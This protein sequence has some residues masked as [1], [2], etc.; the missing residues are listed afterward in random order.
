MAIRQQCQQLERLTEAYLAGIVLLDEYRR[1]RSE[2]ERRS[3]ALE[4]QQRQLTAPV[5][6]REERADLSRSRENFCQRIRPG[7]EQ[8]T[9]EQKRK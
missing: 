7:R 8:A 6:R 9:F 4:E 5:D 1:R 2:R 3:Q